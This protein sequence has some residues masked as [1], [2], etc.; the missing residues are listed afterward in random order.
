MLARI[1]AIALGV[2]I[3]LTTSDA[4]A[5]S[6]MPGIG[7]I[8]P[9][10]RE[11]PEGG[12]IYVTVLGPAPLRADLLVGGR[13]VM[14][15][16]V[17]EFDY[18]TYFAVNEVR[19]PGPELEASRVI[20][21]LIDD[22]YGTRQD[23]VVDLGLQDNLAP[24]PPM[25]LSV[26]Q[27]IQTSF[28]TCTPIVGEALAVRAKVTPSTSTDV[29]AY[30]LELG[31]TNEVLAVGFAPSDGE[32][33]LLGY[34]APDAMGACVRVV[35]ID[36]GGNEAWITDCANPDPTPDP[37]PDPDPMNDPDTNSG[38]LA[39]EFGRGCAC[40]NETGDDS[41]PYAG[42]LLLLGVFGRHRWRRSNIV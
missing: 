27:T 29:I 37:D 34:T 4:A 41:T 25:N 32:V 3:A 6:F 1:S 28:D 22:T 24:E 26:E 15:L 40:T 17:R 35:A 31:E 10:T 9:M 12:V 18:G 7:P 23:L 33:D 21:R 20:V 2:A 30:R 13:F 5:C 36:Q 38:P 19:L 39:Q 8:T 16:D 11:M 14:P 42:L